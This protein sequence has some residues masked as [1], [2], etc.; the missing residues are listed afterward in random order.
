MEKLLEFLAELVKVLFGG[1]SE[2]PAPEKPR[3]PPV[4]ETVT[5]WEGGPPYRLSGHHRLG[6]GGRGWL[7][8]SDAQDGEH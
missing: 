3:E 1:G 5:G 4:E 8:G 6:A 7:Q 2:S